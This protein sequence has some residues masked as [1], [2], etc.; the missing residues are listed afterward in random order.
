MEPVVETSFGKLR[1]ARRT[2]LSFSAASPSRD[3][4]SARFG[5]AHPS[6][7]SLGGTSARRRGSPQPRRRT[8]R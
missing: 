4:R 7:R 5:F 2:T 1:E 6:R 8:L 3:P